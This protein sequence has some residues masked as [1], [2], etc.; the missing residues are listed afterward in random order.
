MTLEN[1]TSAPVKAAFQQLK[2]AHSRKWGIAAR[3]YQALGQATNNSGYGQ[4]NARSFH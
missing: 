3:T 4:E 2:Q 1:I